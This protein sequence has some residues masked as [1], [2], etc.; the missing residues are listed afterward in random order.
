M[1]KVEITDDAMEYI[2]QKNA[3]SITV[4]MVNYGG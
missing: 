3:D 1:L 2:L 4:D